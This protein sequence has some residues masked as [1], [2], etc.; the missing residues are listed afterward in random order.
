MAIGAEIAPAHPAVIGT[1]RVGT[2]MVG[3]VD[4]A[5]APARHD[6]ARGWSEGG[7]RAGNGSVLTGV[8]GWFCGETR[9]GCGLTRA[10]WQQR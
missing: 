1:V 8:A 10:L 3:G 4:Y 7:L 9:K 6:D 5:T 2:K